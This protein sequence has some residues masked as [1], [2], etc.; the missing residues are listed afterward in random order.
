MEDSIFTRI[1]KGEIPCDK[2][3][4]D[5]KTIA[6]LDIKPFFP[7]HTLVVP[8]IQ[9][10]QFD[11]LPSEDYRALFQTVQKVAK[12]LRSTLGT[13]RVIVQIFGF[14]VPHAHVH[15]MPANESK[16]FFQA[17]ANHLKNEPYPYQPTR[18]EQAALAAKLRLEDNL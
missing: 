3:Y 10:D 14:D 5:T 16:Q 1:I 6:F 4:E 15:I 11:D 8:K 12:H 13:K 17:A 18:Q 2:I 9:V 7:G